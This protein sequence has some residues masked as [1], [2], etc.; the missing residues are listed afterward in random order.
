MALSPPLA[1]DS[2]R[3][4][5]EHGFYVVENAA[6][7]SIAKQVDE[8]GESSRL[9][10]WQHFK[11]TLLRD[12]RIRPIIEPF[13]NEANPR[14]CSTF[15]SDPLHIYCFWP[16]PQ[17]HRLVVSIWSPGS[18]VVFYDHSHT[19]EATA[20]MASNGLFEMPPGPLKTNKRVPI[21][22]PMDQ[23][24]VVIQAVRCGCRRLA[25]FTIAY[26]FEN[27]R[28]NVTTA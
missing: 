6:I 27:P 22:A 1:V 16:Q 19:G 17:E 23:G 25:G 10:S 9:E 24:G 28:D 20:V 14:I 21:E 4:L 5:K 8:R 26:G 13:I 2:V 18:K 7:G 11:P 3:S 15:G 12:E